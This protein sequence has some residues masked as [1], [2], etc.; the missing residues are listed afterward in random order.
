[1]SSVLIGSRDVPDRLSSNKLRL[2][3]LLEIDLVANG[4]LL[5]GDRVGGA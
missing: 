2:G 5:V 3:V 4:T 1:M